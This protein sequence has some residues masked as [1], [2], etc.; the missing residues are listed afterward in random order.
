M[1]KR[2]SADYSFIIAVIISIL[3]KY[4]P[5][6]I[7]IVESERG[8][9][10]RGGVDVCEREKQVAEQASKQMMSDTCRQGITWVCDYEELITVGEMSETASP[11]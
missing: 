1:V 7:N 5:L 4:I 3:N 9:E 2:V 11:A 8:V 6:L 10:R